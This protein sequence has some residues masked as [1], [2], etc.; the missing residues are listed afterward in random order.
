MV[1][2]T[3]DHLVTQECGVFTFS[4]DI[5]VWDRTHLLGQ[6]LEDFR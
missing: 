4:H 2:G 1:E 3:T 6:L 5:V